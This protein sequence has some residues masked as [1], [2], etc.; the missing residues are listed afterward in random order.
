MAST[1]SS[2][3]E[4]LDSPERFDV[5][6]LPGYYD[7]GEYYKGLPWDPHRYREVTTKVIQHTPKVKMVIFTGQQYS[8]HKELEALRPVMEHG[9]L[10]GHTPW[11]F[12][13][14]S[15]HEYLKVVR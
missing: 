4:K 8:D 14:P 12:V 7:F 6:F 9:I 2:L 5:I 15:K 3:M 10:L 13:N 11:N 1:Y